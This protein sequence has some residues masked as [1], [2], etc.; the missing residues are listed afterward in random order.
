M[1]DSHDDRAGGGT[2]RG[3]KPRGQGG[4]GGRPSAGQAG[5]G[6]GQGSQPQGG[7]SGGGPRGSARG[8]GAGPGAQPGGQYQG[9]R[10]PV[11]RRPTLGDIFSMPETMDQLKVGVATYLAIGVGLFLAAVLAALVNA[12]VTGSVVSGSLGLAPVVAALLALRQREHITEATAE[13]RHA[14]GGVTAAVGTLAMGI[15]AGLGGTIANSLASPFSAVALGLGDLVVPL[16]VV[17]V[18]AA[19][20]A[21]VL[22]VLVTTLDR[23][24]GPAGAGGG[25]G[26]P[27]R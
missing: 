1:P 2:G 27:P 25:Q 24:R 18:A 8:Q 26:H 20:T 7:P 14:T 23:S 19:A 21:V 11:Q 22:S 6:S 10:Q 3:G 9:T 12:G 15:L 16:F 13:Q 4:Q 17:T 5:S